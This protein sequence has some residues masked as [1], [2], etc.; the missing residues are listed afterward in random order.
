MK[1]AQSI[2]GVEVR[3]VRGEN[4]GDGLFATRKFGPGESVVP[5]LGQWKRFSSIADKCNSKTEYV[6]PTGDDRRGWALAMEPETLAVKIN[7][8][9]SRYYHNTLQSYTI[10]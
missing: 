1:Q 6:T 7:D 4:I 2:Y 9:R 10:Q 5:V 3:R 8:F